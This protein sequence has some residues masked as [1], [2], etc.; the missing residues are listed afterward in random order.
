MYNMVTRVGNT[1]IVQLKFA[2]RVEFKWSHQNQK[3]RCANEHRQSFP[4][5]HIYQISTSPQQS[6]KPNNK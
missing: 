4:N 5:A 3:G 2:K 6:R 1:V